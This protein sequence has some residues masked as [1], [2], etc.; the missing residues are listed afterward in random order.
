MNDFNILGKESFVE[1][2]KGAN[3]DF[4]SDKIMDH[5]AGTIFP[6]NKQVQDDYFVP[7]I[8]QSA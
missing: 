4:T 2:D 8:V 5:T 6:D 3:H 1:N 7:E